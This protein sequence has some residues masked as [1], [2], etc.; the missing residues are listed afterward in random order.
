M[1]GKS[2]IIALLLSITMLAT[3]ATACNDTT[4]S[5]SSEDSKGSSSSDASKDDSSTAD[6]D[7][8]EKPESITLM[9]DGTFLIAENGEAVL[10]KGYEDLY[11]I[12]LIINHPV[13]N[14]Y[15][16][17]VNLAFTTDAAP[18]VLILTSNYYM[19]YAANGALFDITDLYEKSDVKNNIVDQSIIDAIRVDGKLFGLPRERGNGTITY[20]RGDWM[21][22]LNLEAPKN[23]D[24]F[25]N[26]LREFKNNNPDGLEPEKVIPI[27]SA[28]LVN[29]EFPLDIYLR[30]FYWTATPDFVERD[31]VWVDGMS[32]DVMVDA[33]E[34]MVSAFDEGL[35][36][37]EIV[38]NKTSTCR[39]NFYAGSVGA[40]NYWAGTWNLNLHKNTVANIPDAT[41]VP[42]PPIEETFY[43]ERAPIPI[44][45]TSKAKN[46]EGIFEYFLKTLIDNGDGQSLWTFGVEGDAGSATYSTDANG[47]ITMLPSIEDPAK[48][49]TKTWADPALSITNWAPKY[50]FDN[51]ITNSLEM[52]QDNMVVYSLFP[53]SDNINDNIAELNAIK[54]KY[55]SNIVYGEHSIE[56][57]LQKY[58]DEAKDYIKVILDDLN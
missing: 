12:D 2:K 10:E 42:I 56:D 54:A 25:I 40:F 14:E 33:L 58:Q 52:F 51:L 23:Y 19:N 41:V 30:E 20:V 43:V 55:V 38:T 57:G 4:S 27:T 24:E 37:K 53:S 39:D 7:K 31:G 5:S 3:I 18:D 1:K 21:D 36:D 48:N 46:P 17:K 22:K 49:F 47:T 45:I 16:E 9:V 8:V 35:I 29:N 28:G 44:C 6:T 50:E 32:E 11:G 15:Y 34:R 13:H 26:M